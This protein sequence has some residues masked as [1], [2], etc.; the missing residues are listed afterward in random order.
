MSKLRKR[1]KPPSRNETLLT[2]YADMVRLNPDNEVY[3]KQYAELLLQMG[4]EA[5]GLDMLRHLHDLLLKKSDTRR[6]DALIKQYPMIGRV[7]EAQHW[8]EDLQELLPAFVRNRLWI[9]LHQQRLSEGQHLFHR[10]DK[11]NTLYFVCAGELAEFSEAEDGTPILLSL[12]KQGDVVAENKLLNAG[13]HKS[14][15]VANKKS[16][17]VKLPRKQMMQALSTTPVLKKIIERKVERR[18][19]MRFISESPVLQ[20]IPLDMRQHLAEGSYVQEYASQTIIHKAGEKLNHVDLII[21]GEAHYQLDSQTS[22]GNLK[23]FRS[24]TLIGETSAIHDFGCPADLLTE[25]GVTIVH[26]S[27]AAFI[28]VVEAYSPL[29]KKLTASTSVQRVQLM[30]KLNELHTQELRQ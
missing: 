28:N 7:R 2:V 8:Q 11:L 24:G 22:G 27:Y 26:I 17:V 23:T 6:A 5:S 9:K 18:S 30:S 21:A 13:R 19:L 20:V 1:P 12:I 3:I 16:L 10:G 29:R 14:D 25:S 15:V 4:K